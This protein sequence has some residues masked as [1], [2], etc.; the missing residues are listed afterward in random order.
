MMP[1][2]FRAG[3]VVGKWDLGEVGPGCP[4]RPRGDRCRTRSICDRLDSR[5]RTVSKD[6]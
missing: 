2:S 6:A 1:Q 3:A 5:K 4:V